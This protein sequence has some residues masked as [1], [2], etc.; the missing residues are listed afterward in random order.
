MAKHQG[1]SGH[2][3]RGRRFR[4]GAKNEARSSSDWER[5]GESSWGISSKRLPASCLPV[6][7]GHAPLPTGAGK[8]DGKVM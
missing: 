4:R 5:A 7:S 1:V 3:I 6:P 2:F 8:P